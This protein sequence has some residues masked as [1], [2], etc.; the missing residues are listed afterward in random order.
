MTFRLPTDDERCTA[1]SKGSGERCKRW[2]RD[3]TTVCMVHGAG[4]KKRVL[5]GQRKDPKLAAVVHGR[6]SRFRDRILADVQDYI[7]DP[8]MWEYN[9]LAALCVGS[10]ERADD[11][12]E[13][14]RRALGVLE[15]SLHAAADDGGAEVAALVVTAASTATSTEA[16]RLRAL[17]Q[18]GKVVA[19]RHKQ[20][21]AAGSVAIPEMIALLR[22]FQSLV[23]QL[24]ADPKIERH[25]IPDRFSMAVRSIAMGHEAI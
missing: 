18:L 9:R 14:S 24:V 7:N 5:A 6:Y 12:A 11:L 13:V 15:R 20:N 8:D 25:A 21:Q 10:L 19:A 22:W 4:T 17:E 1:R 3:G 23:V 2:R 16:L